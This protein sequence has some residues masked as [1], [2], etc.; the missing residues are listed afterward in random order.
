[1]Y[2]FLVPTISDCLHMNV[3]HLKPL[4]VYIFTDLANNKTKLWKAWKFES[5]LNG[6]IKNGIHMYALF[7]KQMI[8]QL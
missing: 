4:K 6:Y 2:F 5:H 3:K 7:T 1:M 8:G